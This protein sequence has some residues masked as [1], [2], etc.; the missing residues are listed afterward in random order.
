MLTRRSRRLGTP[1]SVS[2]TPGTDSNG[3]TTSLTLTT[4]VQ[5]PTTLMNVVGIKTVNVGY[6]SQVV[7]G[8]TK[9]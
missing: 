8:Q 6:T 2:V 3:N 1:A 5:M 9:L 7:W 4:N